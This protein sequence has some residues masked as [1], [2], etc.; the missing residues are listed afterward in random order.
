MQSGRYPSDT[1][2]Q[3]PVETGHCMKRTFHICLSSHDEVMFRDDD[4]YNR[5]FNTFAL[6]LYKTDSIG[7]V[8]SFMSDHVHMLV[9]TED[10]D[11]FMRAYRMP[12]TK[13]FN[14]RYGRHG[15]LGEPRHFVLEIKGLHHHLAAASY[16]L[17]NALHHGIVPIPYAYPHSSVNVIFQREMGKRPER[18]LIPRTSYYRHIGRHASFPDSYVMNR[19]GLFL[20]ESVLDIPQMENMF[21]TPRNF[22]YYMGRRTSEEWVKEQ[23]NDRNGTAS[24]TLEVIESNVRMTTLKDM[25]VLESGR[26]DYRRI[27]DVDLCREIDRI[28]KE[29]LHAASI[30][31]L[32]CEEKKN[33]AR[34][35]KGKYYS[36]GAQLCRCLALNYRPSAD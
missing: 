6:A 26:A 16:I 2:V 5:G 3:T 19:S 8:E 24:V 23:E 10:P 21:M 30:Y 12:Y 22:D 1:S 34:L 25:L 27:S 33:L 15:R 28:V 31:S 11:R 7:L 36:G 18:D 17:R 20:R 14:N 4:D 9:Q 29:D 32:S 13:Y 35:L